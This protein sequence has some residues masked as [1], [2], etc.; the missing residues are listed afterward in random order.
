LPSFRSI[1]LVK[2]FQRKLKLASSFFR[3]GQLKAHE[4]EIIND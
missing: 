3:K 4:Y 2:R 1:F